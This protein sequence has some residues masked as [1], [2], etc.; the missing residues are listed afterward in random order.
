M[1]DLSLAEAAD[2]IGVSQRQARNLVT[3]GNIVLTA[4]GVV[5]ADSVS[6]FLR[7]RGLVARRVWSKETAWAAIGLLAGIDISRGAK[8][9]IAD[10]LKVTGAL[11]SAPVLVLPTRRSTAT[12]ASRGEPHDPLR[13]RCATSSGAR[14]VN[15]VKNLEATASSWRTCPKVNARKND[16]SI[17]GAYARSKIRLI[18]P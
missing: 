4:R 8:R 7:D 1:K 14:S 6:A 2:R 5:D 10:A 18:P 13:R 17:D 3:S 11:T 15:L 9:L 12:R 16:P